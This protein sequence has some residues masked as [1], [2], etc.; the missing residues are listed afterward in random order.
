MRQFQVPVTL[1]FF[2]REE[3]T[4]Q[5]LDRI[6]MIRPKKM[7]LICD[8][9]RDLAEEQRVQEC[10][11]RVENRI[12][13]KCEVIKNYASENLGVYNRIGKGAQW[14]LEREESAIFLED[15]N[16]PDLTFFRF[17]EEMLK[18]YKDDTRVLW[19]CGTNYLKEYEPQDGSSYLFTKQMQPCGWASWKNK[20][21]RFY[22]GELKLWK[23][24]Y[25]KKRI[26]YEYTN[27]VLLEQ[28]MDFWN[29]EF[30]RLLS[31]MRLWSWDY[32]M[33]FT[34]RINGLYGIVPK[35]N[36]ITNIGVDN[37]SEHGGNTFKNVMT[38]RFCGLPVKS[39]DFP[40]RHP[41]VLL[42]DP[43]FE[44]KLERKIIFPLKYRLKVKLSIILK[45]LFKVNRDDSLTRILQKRL[46]LSIGKHVF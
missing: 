29:R 8:G 18:Y 6:A 10:R 38:E 27:K 42:T 40:L 30:R 4:I 11:K 15:D 26:I 45:R 7:Y 33:S 2:K 35:Y 32:Q 12:D 24:Q 37:D 19:V 46:N 41:K 43:V 34:L 13:W 16:L 28:D 17:C 9:G 1:F 5:V 23:D 39:L 25:L 44:K 14:V 36:L 22:D 21:A 3:K 31:G 20:F